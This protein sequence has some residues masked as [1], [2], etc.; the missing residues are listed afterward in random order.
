MSRL[1]D[2]N[3][4]VYCVRIP[5]HANTARKYQGRRQVVPITWLFMSVGCL[6]YPFPIIS[7]TNTNTKSSTI[8]PRSYVCSFAI[9]TVLNQT[10]WTSYMNLENWSLMFWKFSCSVL[11]QHKFWRTP[12]FTGSVKRRTGLKKVQML[13]MQRHFW[14]LNSWTENL[15]FKHSAMCEC[16]A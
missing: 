13:Q 6:L 8:P 2:T 14:K 10:Q 7:I 4:A 15:I 16:E 3:T 9:T 5:A 12:F 1:L 11:W